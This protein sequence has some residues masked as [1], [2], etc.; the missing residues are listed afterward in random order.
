MTTELT[1]LST[2]Q[3][4][5]DKIIICIE[6]QDWIQDI[7]S[8]PITFD[9]TETEILEAIRPGVQEKFDVD[10][11]DDNSGWLYKVRKATDNRNIYILPNSTA[12]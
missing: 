9:S 10:I 3:E 5:T 6:G 7:G 8:S 4:V 1:P 2:E 12:G 11:K